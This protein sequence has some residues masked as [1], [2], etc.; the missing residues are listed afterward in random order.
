MQT[1]RAFV[2][3]GSLLALAGCPSRARV[4]GATIRAAETYAQASGWEPP[5][6]ER[7]D[8]QAVSR[9]SGEARLTPDPALASAAAELARRVARDPQGRTP[10]VRVIQAVT[11]LAG[12]TDPLPVVLTVKGAASQ[13]DAEVERGMR[14]VLQSERV[15]HVGVGRAPADGGEVVVVAATRRRV[16]LDPVA[17]RVATGARVSLHG[18][19]AEGLRDPAMVVTRPDGH[20]EETPLGD[21]PEFLGQFPAGERGVWQ[22]EVSADSDAGSTVVANF[23]VYV[24]TD[25]P[26]TPEETAAVEAEEPSAVEAA[27]LRSI[28]ESRAR[29]HLPPLE[30][31]APLV[32]VARAHSRDMA[33]HHYVAHNSREGA[34]PGQRLRDAG[35][36]SGLS[37]ENVA[38]GYGAREIHDGLMVSPG[39]RANILNPRV[40]HVGVGVAR[41]PGAMGALLVTQ[42]FIEVA[43]DVDPRAAAAELL[44]T[45]NRGREARGAPALQV[46]PQL[47][48]AAERAA[49]ALFESPQRSQDDALAQATSALRGESLM[50]RRIQLVAA[51]GPRYQDAANMQPLFERE[52]AAVG[53]GVAQGDRPGAPPRS[54]FV[55]YVLGVPR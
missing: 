44:A 41:E 30:L 19:L 29:A 48:A 45:I 22:V 33:D 51:F 4:S 3:A 2:V 25:P 53:I 55:V 6:A 14:E 34:T 32:E 5:A 36:V 17:R 18:R 39:H 42:D 20:T 21:G 26:E 8:Y 15:T 47:Q 52:S 1:S 23:P 31:M 50:F 38:R 46:R 54:V 9:A 11:W 37:L 27:L 28:N 12:V 49:R 7:T 43:R 16:R 13:V 10:S 24:D 40:T 35:L